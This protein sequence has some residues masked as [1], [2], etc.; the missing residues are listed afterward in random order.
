M[1]AGPSILIGGS[2]VKTEGVGPRRMMRQAPGR[3]RMLTSL[4]WKR[5][6]R[7]WSSTGS[8]SRR[9]PRCGC[10]VAGGL[11]ADLGDGLELAG[12]DG[13]EQGVL[14]LAE[15]ADLDLAALQVVADAA[16][17]E[18]EAQAGQGG[19]QAALADDGDPPR[20]RCGR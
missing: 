9:V 14:Q 13:L 5:T 1:R 19:E 12:D 8:C 7:P 3:R 2:A 4:W 17:G 11:A 6:R 15:A 10:G 18:L 20:R 16:E